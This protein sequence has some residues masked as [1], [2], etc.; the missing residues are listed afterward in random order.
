MAQPDTIAVVFDPAELKQITDAIGVLNATL[1][2]KLKTLS[3]QDM[4]EI[5]KMG[6]KSVAFVQKAFEYSQIHP[7]LR[8][9]FLDVAA[10]QIDLDSL[11]TLHRLDRS[12]NPVVNALSD[13][14]AL[15]GSEAYQAALLFYANTKSAAKLRLPGAQGVYDDLASRFPGAGSSS[16][17]AAPRT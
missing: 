7:D 6:D 1:L 3:T 8:P 4:R 13:S 10:F 9:A 5:P 14:M 17:P 2:P 16:K 12:L 15:A 11:A